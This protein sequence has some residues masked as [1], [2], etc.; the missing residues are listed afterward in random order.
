MSKTYMHEV[1]SSPIGNFKNRAEWY[2]LIEI[3]MR[4]FQDLFVEGVNSVMGSKHASVRG[5]PRWSATLQELFCV[6]AIW[7]TIISHLN[8]RLRQ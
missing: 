3:S 2:G 7:H 5:S 6:F 8:A 4:G 1:G